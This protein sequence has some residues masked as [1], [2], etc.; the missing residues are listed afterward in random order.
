MSE[1]PKVI[2]VMGP[3][4]AG[5]GTQAEMLAAKIGYK[6]FSTG[7]AFREVSAQDTELGRR[8][9]E[10]IDNGYLAPPEMAAEIVMTA[11]KKHLENGEGLVFDGT[12][13]TV[14]EAKIVDDFFEKNKYGAPLPIYISV[15]KE[16]MERRN[17]KRVFCLDA[18]GG[19]FPVFTEE[20]KA[21]CEEKS[22]HEGRRPDDDPE[23]FI[24]RWDEFQSQTCPVVKEY[25]ERNI[26]HEIDGMSSIEEVHEEVMKIIDSFKR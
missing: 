11:V 20:D 10:T 2:Y 9:K 25:M 13:R 24:T 3:P 22:G 4:G 18:K 6:Q 1:L 8:V 14:P 21:K 15:D 16:E 26:L 5:K 7:N 19:D 23:K 12:P 17:S